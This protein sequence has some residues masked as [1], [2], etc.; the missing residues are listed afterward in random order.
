MLLERCP[1]CNAKIAPGDTQ[2][3]D[4][5]EDLV[6]HREELRKAAT[7]KKTLTHKEKIEMAQRAAAAAARGRGFGVETSEETRMRTFDK[8]EAEKVQHEM[9]TAWATA[10]IGLVLGVIFLKIGADKYKLGGGFAGWKDLSMA[11][12]RHGDALFGESFVSLLA[13]GLALSSFLCL[14]GQTFRALIA[15]K[16]ITAV[17]RGAKPEVVYIH[18][19]TRFGLV[20]ASLCF[21]PAGL[22]FGLLMRMFGRDED[23]KSLGGTMLTASLAVMG[24]LVLNFLWGLAAGLKPAPEKT[25]PGDTEKAVGFL[26]RV[27]AV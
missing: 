10:F 7:A 3:L 8:H 15:H 4:C 13:L 5:G 17:A 20:L 22:L 16:S 18:P 11:K 6:K 2:C 1:K 9:I 26:R 14:I 23:T 27:A 21:P 12:L 19:A 25:A 24:I